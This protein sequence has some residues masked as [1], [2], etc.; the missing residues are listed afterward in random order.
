MSN[1]HKTIAQPQ[2]PMIKTIGATTTTKMVIYYLN[3]TKIS[4]S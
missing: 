2:K 3:L 1:E 4:K